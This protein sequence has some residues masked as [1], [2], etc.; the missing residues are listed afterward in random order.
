MLICILSKFR[1]A[2]YLSSNF[3]SIY[4]SPSPAKSTV[5]GGH[6]FELQSSQVNNTSTKYKIQSVLQEVRMPHDLYQDEKTYTANFDFVIYMLL[7][8]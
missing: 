4:S 1:P 3:L 6:M 7:L 5:A 2:R 8:F